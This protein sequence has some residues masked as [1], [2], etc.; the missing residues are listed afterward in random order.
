MMP[1]KQMMLVLMGIDRDGG[2]DVWRGDVDDGW[3]SKVSVG[4]VVGGQWGLG[5]DMQ[6]LAPPARGPQALP[7]RGRDPCCRS[8]LDAF[9]QLALA[10]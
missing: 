1:V 8:G 9:P 7:P 4:G 2:D 6:I 3:P 5:A 10:S